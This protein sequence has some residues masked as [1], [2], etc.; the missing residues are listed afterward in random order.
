V[1]TVGIILA[2]SYGISRMLG[3]TVRLSILVACG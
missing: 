2:A 1:I 3:L